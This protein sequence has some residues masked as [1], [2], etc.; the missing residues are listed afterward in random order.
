MNTLTRVA[1]WLLGL[2]CL[3]GATKADAVPFDFTGT[4][5]FIET[6][7]CFSGFC[8][9][10]FFN[11][12][13]ILISERAPVSLSGTLGPLQAPGTLVGVQFCCLPPGVAAPSVPDDCDLCL[14][15]FGGFATLFVDDPGPLG[16]ELTAHITLVGVTQDGERFWELA[17]PE[18]TTLLLWGTTMVGFGLAARRRRRR[19]R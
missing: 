14:R 4:Y 1:S 19:Q 6:G 5:S 16:G 13:V 17:T 18:P 3:L 2:L 8:T 12:P 15:V 9:A 10:D 7:G 11:A